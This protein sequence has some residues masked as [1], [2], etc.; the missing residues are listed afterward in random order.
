MHTTIA[1]IAHCLG[2]I[3]IIYH[4]LSVNLLATLAKL[5]DTPSS[6]HSVDTPYLNADLNASQVSCASPR[7]TST[8]SLYRIGFSI[9]AYPVLPT[10]RFDTKTNLLFHTR[11]TGIPYMLQLGSSSAAL[12]ILHNIYRV[13]RAKRHELVSSFAALLSSFECQHTTTY[14]LTVSLAPITI[15]TSV[16]SKSSLISSISYTISYGTLASANNT[17]SCPGILPATKHRHTKER[18]RK[19]TR[20]I[21]E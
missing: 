14:L 11:N 1:T 13:E 9:P 3:P 5:L 8:L 10:V 19:S 6:S 2:G 16:F 15:V 12:L 21:R 7:I 18:T 17:L 20:E 4:T